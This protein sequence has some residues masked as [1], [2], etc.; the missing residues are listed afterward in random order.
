MSAALFKH[1]LHYV[2]DPRCDFIYIHSARSVDMCSS[3]D[4]GFLYFVLEND[5]TITRHTVNAADPEDRRFRV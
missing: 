5:P 4:N 3:V 2:L 1:V